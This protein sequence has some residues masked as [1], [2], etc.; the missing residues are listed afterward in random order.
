MRQGLITLLFLGILHINLAIAQDPQLPP[1]FA[2]DIQMGL[3]S[4]AQMIGSSAEIIGT[5]ANT[6][7]SQVF[8]A[9]IATSYAQPYAWKLTL[10]DRDVVNA[11]SS[12][13]GQV[14]V[15]GG[16]LPAIGLNK[17]LWAAVLSHE[18]AHTA[19]RHGVTLYLRE[20]YNQRMIQYYRAQVLAGNN[21][22]N[23]SLAAFR[24]SSALLETKL[25]R[26]QEH[27]ADQYGMLMMAR[28]GYHPD[29]VFALHHL[30]L[31]KTGE[32]SKFGAFFSDHPRWETRDQRSDRVYSDALAEFNRLWPDA[33]ASPGGG[34]PMVAF[35]G[36]P[37]SLENVQGGYVDLRV[38]LYCRNSDAPV[39]LLVFLQRKHQPVK[40][41]NPDFSDK[42]G[43][44]LLRQRLGC[45][46]KEDALPISIQIPAAAVPDRDRSVQA[47]VFVSEDGALV[48]QSNRF[49]LRFPK[50]RK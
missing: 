21:S 12:P 2:I 27:Q 39:D 43:N 28:A 36:R 13:G 34:P 5:P 47:E 18:V 33:T 20:L 16:L 50:K 31:M 29:F 8:D 40:A 49:E 42:N 10:V 22:A 17:G 26:D 11:A 3:A 14:Y 48:A 25:Q 19:L 15:Y 45:P 4:R 32:Q 7:G 23:Y 46:H 37:E 41:I 30:L 35:L 38:P 6:V 9:L 24:I 1:D 44:F